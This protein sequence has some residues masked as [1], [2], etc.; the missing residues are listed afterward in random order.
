MN[1]KELVTIIKQELKKLNELFLIFDNKK[2]F[3][4][5]SYINIKIIIITYI[6]LLRKKRNRVLINMINLI[7]IQNKIK[8]EYIISKFNSIKII[9]NKIMN[10]NYIILRNHNVLLKL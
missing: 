1:K 3:V 4:E 10:I 2:L 8:N 5:E 6:K 7:K 9:Y